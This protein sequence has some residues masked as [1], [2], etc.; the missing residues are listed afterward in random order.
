MGQ[1]IFPASETYFLL[2]EAA[3][4]GYALSG[5][6][7]NNFDEG[8]KASFNYLEKFGSSNA[9]TASSTPEADAKAYQAANVTTEST[10]YLANYD[11]ATT[12]AQRL[13]AIITQK[14]IALNFVDSYEAWT[15]FRRTTYPKIVNGSASATA[16]FASSQSSSTRVDKLAVRSIYPQNEYN[17]NSNTPAG[18]NV[19]TNKIFWDPASD[20]AASN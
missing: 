13:E 12:Y 4:N 7:K 5:T 19:F 18:I 15:E 8:I 16:N 2:A 3:L 17:L 14:Y 20:T 6:A 1:I 9:V 10:R 11:L